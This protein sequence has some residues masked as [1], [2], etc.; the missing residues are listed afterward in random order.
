MPRLRREFPRMSESAV[1]EALRQQEEL[2]GQFLRGLS[3]P[4]YEGLQ[5]NPMDIMGL[6]GPMPVGMF[7]TGMFKGL[8]GE[9][10]WLESKEIADTLKRYPMEVLDP[11]KDVKVL[12]KSQM[13]KTVGEGYEGAYFGPELFMSDAGAILEGLRAAKKPLSSF[14]NEPRLRAVSGEPTIYQIKESAD[15]MRVLRHEL[16]HLVREQQGKKY[17]NLP[18]RINPEEATVDAASHMIVGTPRTS[19]L[20]RLLNR[21]DLP[22]ETLVKAMDEAEVTIQRMR[23]GAK[24]THYE[25]LPERKSIE[26]YQERIGGPRRKNPRR[27]E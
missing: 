27:E 6:A 16:E 23:S 4:L 25:T 10:P 21:F 19:T 15:P 13:A 24:P 2:G 9:Y 26:R 5:P 8:K 17:P 1:A 3:E 14:L 12:P 18:F 7:K 20:A 11:L 22:T